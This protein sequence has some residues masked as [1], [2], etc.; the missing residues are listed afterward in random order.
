MNSLFFNVD[1]C[2]LHVS[3]VAID[4]SLGVH[5]LAYD[6]HL[7]SNIYIC[8]YLL[9][10]GFYFGVYVGAGRLKFIYASA[11]LLTLDILCVV[12]YF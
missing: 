1:T 6:I 7:F 4:Y 12:V 9:L 2:S 11:K 5:H 8:I 10:L 3:Q